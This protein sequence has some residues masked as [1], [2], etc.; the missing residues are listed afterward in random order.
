MQTP[1]P[2]SGG[3][4][5]ESSTWIEEALGEAAEIVR[6]EDIRASVGK[7]C[8]YCNFVQMCPAKSSQVSVIELDGG[9]DDFGGDDE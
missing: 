9:T 5:G 8:R 4:H 1:L 3:D 7:H 6:G 2:A